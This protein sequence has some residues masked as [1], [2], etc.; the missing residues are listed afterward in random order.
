MRS[1]RVVT[2]AV[3]A[4]AGCSP[5]PVP[6]PPSPSPETTAGVPAADADTAGAD[7]GAPLDLDAQARAAWAGRVD[8]T[9]LG[10]AI[11]CWLRLSESRPDDPKPLLALSRAYVT[12]A[13]F[14]VR[15][16]ADMPQ[17]AD[18]L[19]RAID[20]A[21]RAL[22][23]SSPAFSAAVKRGV[24]IEEAVKSV[25]AD[26]MEALA[27]YG[28]S[29]AHYGV[30]KGFTALL[31]YRG[32]LVAA[33]Q[34]VIEIA[35]KTEHA[36]ADRELGT[37]F[38]RVPGFAGGDLARAREHFD[39]ALGLAPE[40]LVTKLRYAEAYAI[41]AKNRE[42]FARL[43]AEIKAA[44]A[45]EADLAPDNLLVKRRADLLAASIDDLFAR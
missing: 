1:F 42:L 20:T 31:M 33:M 4:A 28:T 15:A 36:A 2:I 34:R 11:D 30:D 3:L 21:E 10:R 16:P 40:V 23:A 35:P 45:G 39:K 17:R 32:R 19:E 29:L 13:D 27:V 14:H 7:A 25:E 18:A 43:L 44:D 41:E 26:K 5:G 37:F 9:A 6:A 12:L 38:A 24:S 22:L 8:R